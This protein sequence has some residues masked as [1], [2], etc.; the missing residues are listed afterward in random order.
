MLPIELGLVIL[1]VVCLAYF[2]GY[3]VG[4]RER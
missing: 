3:A 4:R 1:V 2:A